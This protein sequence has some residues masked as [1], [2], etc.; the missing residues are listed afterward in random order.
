MLVAIPYK[1]DEVTFSKQPRTCQQWLSILYMLERGDFK[2]R[3]AEASGPCL[4][5]RLLNCFTCYHWCPH[6]VP[7]SLWINAGGFF[8][9]RFVVSNRIFLNKRF[10]RATGNKVIIY[11]NSKI[12]AIHVFQSTIFV[13]KIRVTVF[14]LPF[15][16]MHVELISL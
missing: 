8:L 12:G 9:Q 14:L 7:V 3:T 11:V 16:L 6:G 1:L 5:K 13:R 2:T 10:N 15:F 4:E